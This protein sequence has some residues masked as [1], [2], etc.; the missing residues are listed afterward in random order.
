MATRNV[1]GGRIVVRAGAGVARRRI[2]IEHVEHAQREAEPVVH[3]ARREAQLDIAIEAR[4]QLVTVAF[5]H[6]VDIA[7][8]ERGIEA[9]QRPRQHPG[10][11]ELRIRLVGEAARGAAI[12]DRS[13]AGGRGERLLVLEQVF[14]VER[15][16]ER[17]RTTFTGAALA[18]LKDGDGNPLNVPQMVSS[19]PMLTTT[20]AS[21]AETQGTANNASSILYGNFRELFIGMRDEV[22]VTVLRE[23]YA[24]YGQVGFLVWMRADVQLAHKASF[25]RLKGIIPA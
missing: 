23:R 14:R 12:A 22:Q 25:S 21:I 15:Q 11:L 16:P 9:A 8:R 17:A 2:G 7:A 6:G 13:H 4:I 20:S 10:T 3:E 5:D 1:V 18:K 19:V 24:D